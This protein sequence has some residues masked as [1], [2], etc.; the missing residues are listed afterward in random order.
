MQTVGGLVSLSL[1]DP[2]S[3]SVW[4]P[5]DPSYSEMEHCA[6]SLQH[7]TNQTACGLCGLCWNRKCNT[8]AM[9]MITKGKFVL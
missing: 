7:N 9:Q 5:V 1:C 8:M 6:A 3:E 4:L 2:I